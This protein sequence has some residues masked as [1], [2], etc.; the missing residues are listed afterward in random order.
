LQWWHLVHHPHLMVDTV[1]EKQLRRS[2]RMSSVSPI[3]YGIT[4][5]LA[6]VSPWICVIVYIGLS[7]YFA[8]G[9]SA[10][11]LIAM[12]KAAD[13]AAGIAPAAELGNDDD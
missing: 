7:G 12:Q 5:P 8:R 10:R 1:T 13:E 2:L 4:I 6:F 11:A 3:V 9:P